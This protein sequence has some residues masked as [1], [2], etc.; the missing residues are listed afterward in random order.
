MTAIFFALISYLGWGAGDVSGAVVSRKLGA[1]STSLWAYFLGWIF[2][3]FLIPSRLSDLQHLTPN[4]LVLNL[5]LGLIGV[6]STLA[7]NEAL[8]VGNASL[9]GTIA[10]SFSALVVIFSII[11]LG[12]NINVLQSVAIFVI[13]IGIILSTLD[14]EQIKGRNLKLNKGIIL[15]L[16]TML[17]WGLY[18]TFIKIPVRQIGWFWPAY[19]SL[20]MFPVV[21]LLTK[22]RK[23][24]IYRPSYRGALFPLLAAVILLRTAELSFNV[25]ISKGLTAI[26]APIA[27]SYPTFFAPLA[28]FVFK[29]PITKQ[30]ITGIIT[31]L[32]GI[33]FLSFVSA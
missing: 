17:I 11:F 20:S 7:F 15:A 32:I 24:K 2:L 18:F 8:R 19:I 27:G 5:I 6:V 12:E 31:T 9:V 3:G 30:Q 33:V 25:A 22:L 13:F 21:F 23:I 1:Y 29:D 28:A 26:V 4:I 14:I 10:S 16:L